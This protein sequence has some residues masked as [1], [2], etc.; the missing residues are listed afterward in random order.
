MFD[1]KIVLQQWT[2]DSYWI[3]ILNPDGSLIGSWWTAIQTPYTMLA[4]YDDTD[5]TYNFEY[6]AEAIT[7]T[8]ETEAK[9][10]VFRIQNSK[11]WVFLSKKWAWNSFNNLWDETTI[12]S[13]IYS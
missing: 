11:A 12:K 5:P 13:L 1:P 4:Y 10:R 3:A 2:V 9:W 7:W 8:L 6:Y